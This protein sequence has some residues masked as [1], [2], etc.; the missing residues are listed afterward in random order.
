MGRTAGFALLMAAA[1][2][3]LLALV[4]AAFGRD[5]WL[6][7]LSIRSKSEKIRLRLAVESGL[8]YGAARLVQETYPLY[9]STRSSRADS[10]MPREPFG[11]SPHR[12]L[13]PS[14]A[15]GEPWRDTLPASSDSIDNN[16]DGLT[17]EPDEGQGLY[18]PGEPF[19][20]LDGDGKYTAWSGRLRGGP[21]PFEHRFALMIDALDGRIPVNAGYLDDSDRAIR[22]TS[23]L[24]P[25]LPVPNGVPD[26]RDPEADPYHTSLI[27][28]LNNLGSIVR[29]GTGW[30]RRLDYQTGSPPGSGHTFELSWLG[31]DILAHRPHGGY[32]SLDDLRLTLLSL[33]YT[34]QEWDRFEPFLDA[35]PYD[36]PAEYGRISTPVYQMSGLGTD[37]DDFPP[38]VPIHLHTARSETFQ[39]VWRYLCCRHSTAIDIYGESTVWPIPCSRT[40]GTPIPFF[41]MPFEIFSDEARALADAAAKVRRTGIVS[42]QALHQALADEAPSLFGTDLADLAVAP[43]YGHHWVQAKA[44][45]AFQAVALDFCPWGD[46]GQGAALWAS[47]GVDRDRDLPGLQE[48][49]AVNFYDIYR[50]HHPASPGDALAGYENPFSNTFIPNIHRLRPQGMTLAPSNRFRIASLGRAGSTAS[51]CRGTF[52]VRESL[53]FAS[54]EDFENL[55]GGAR[56]RDRGITVVDDDPSPPERRDWRSGSDGRF[57]THVATLPR[58]SRRAYASPAAARA[59]G[60]WGYSR[61]FGAICLAPRQGGLRDASLYWSMKEDFDHRLNNDLDGS[62]SSAPGEWTPGENGDFWHEASLSFLPS[63]PL[64][65][66]PFAIA[67]FPSIAGAPESGIPV[68]ATPLRL[69]TSS[70]SLQFQCPGIEAPPGGIIRALSMETWVPRCGGLSHREIPIELGRHVSGGI[71]SDCLAISLEQGDHVHFPAAAGSTPEHTTVSIRSQWK[72]PGGTPVP[73]MGSLETKWVIPP[74]AGRAPPNFH[75]VLTLAADPITS[76]TQIRLYVNG[77]NT[78]MDG[79]MLHTHTDYMQASDIERLNLRQCGSLR[80]F[81]RR[82]DADEVLGLY[83]LGR[84]VE[85]GT[86]SSPLYVFDEPAALDRVQWTGLIPP[87]FPADC[88]TVTVFGYSST[89]SPGTAAWPP[90]TTRKPGTVDRLPAT[91]VKS[92]RYEVHFDCT[93]HPGT[94]LD[95]PVFE[96]IWFTESRPGRSFRWLDLEE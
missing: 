80:L 5:I 47:G 24:F 22:D 36:G 54:Q 84:F 86:Y 49:A 32:R 73:P 60:F 93:S 90:V 94:L 13:N 44:D 57:Q 61:L 51:T 64:A 26:H 83:Q 67:G 6:N 17:D 9:G 10:W 58:P 53:L 75:L 95:T 31:Q 35:G 34:S 21:D 72:N 15:R 82:L 40:G 63:A 7:H 33:G 30:T 42:W 11:T 39:A 4:A 55:A 37:P 45:L 20:D 41:A 18:T 96:S 29:P 66:L 69:S 25:Y 14:Y 88:L 46:L 48:A 19:A 27:H 3:S 1:L 16:A 28:V 43:V 70:L 8:A 52:K 62:G 77:S 76:T 74:P 65:P 92:F 81:N 23:L 50:V 38:Y 56:W 91:P 78:S 12:A 71:D 59:P 85:T 68:P 2:L 89:G 87:G 79:E